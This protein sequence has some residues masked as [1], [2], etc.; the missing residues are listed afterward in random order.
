MN[1]NNKNWNKCVK[2]LCEIA[3]EAEWDKLKSL[4]FN[5]RT[6]IVTDKVQA[7][8]ERYG[9]DNEDKI[10]IFEDFFYTLMNK[11][12]NRLY[13]K[14]VS[15]KLEFEM[16]FISDDSYRYLLTDILAH[17]YGAYCEVMEDWTAVYKYKDYEE[18][19]EYCIF[20]Y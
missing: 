8:L 1:I 16:G 7:V 10:N 20:D 18:G 19:F 15:G 11:L 9:F 12:Y 13:K 2:I 4:S 6:D 14:W 3:N 5:E 17:G